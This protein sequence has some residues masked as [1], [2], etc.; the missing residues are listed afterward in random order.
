M[1]SN[2]IAAGI[3][4]YILE[5]EMMPAAIEYYVKNDGALLPQA[6][7]SKGEEKIIKAIIDLIKD[8]LPLDFTDYK[9]TTISRRIKRRSVSHN[10]TKLESYLAFCKINADE[11]EAL[12]KDFMISVTSFFRDKEAFE[13]LEKNEI[14]EIIEQK[15][16]GEEIKVWVAGCATGE[17]AYTLAILFKEQ[18]RGNQK[19]ITVK[20][21]ATDID[22][23]AVGFAGK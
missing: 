19:N 11:L 22:D 18:L 5:P 15:R 17:E 20:I 1:P 14:P 13:F 12:A 10:F 21:F 4:D 16:E 6:I 23:V 9:Q 2:V 8:K 3:A 7:N